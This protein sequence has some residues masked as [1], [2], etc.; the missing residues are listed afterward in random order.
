MKKVLQ[1]IIL[2]SATVFTVNGLHA[3]QFTQKDLDFW[4][5]E[6][7]SVVKEGR[8]V[9]TDTKLGTNTVTCNECHP[10]ASNTHPE[11][12]P[13]FQKQLGKVATMG[14]M[15]NWCIANPLE[16]KKMALDNPKMTA[17]IAYITHERRGVA[18]APGKH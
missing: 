6:Y 4:S 2:L 7:K 3:D 17:L 10:N 11:T 16:G 9:F 15:I 14:E 18:L 13:K 5:A 12:Y 8:K 1:S